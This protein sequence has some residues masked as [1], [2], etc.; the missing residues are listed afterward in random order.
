M[1]LKDDVRRL[2]PHP[3]VRPSELDEYYHPWNLTTDG[4]LGP[5]D[6][7]RYTQDFRPETPW[8]GFHLFTYEF[9]PLL[10]KSA[11]EFFNWSDVNVEDMSGGTWNITLITALLQRR[12]EAERQLL[13]TL[14]KFNGSEGKDLLESYGPSLPFYDELQLEDCIAWTRWDHGRDAI[15]YTLRYIGELDAIRHWLG[16]VLRQS[17]LRDQPARSSLTD[18]KYAGVWVGGVRSD[19][20][21]RFLFDSP[22][23]LYGLFPID[24]RHHLHRTA[25]KGCFDNDEYYR[26]DG[27]LHALRNI[28]PPIPSPADP[29]YD[30]GYNPRPISGAPSCGE[31]CSIQPPH[32]LKLRPPEARCL[33]SGK[34][35]FDPR[36]PYSSYLFME[37]R[38]PRVP[39]AWSRDQTDLRK[40]LYKYSVATAKPFRL[41]LAYPNLADR[42]MPYHPAIYVIP[43]RPR[44][45]GGKQRIF[46]EWNEG[47]YWWLEE[48]SKS[49]RKKYRR[50][51]IHRYEHPL[52]N[53]DIIWSDF[54]W[55]LVKEVHEGHFNEDP[56][57]YDDYEDDRYPRLVPADGRRIYIT[58]QQSEHIDS[59]PQRRLIALPTPSVRRDMENRHSAS[60][61]PFTSTLPPP[62]PPSRSNPCEWD[63]DYDEDFDPIITNDHE[64]EDLPESV[65]P[66]PYSVSTAGRC[67]RPGRSPRP[68]AYSLSSSMGSRR[69][70]S[71]L[72]RPQGCMREETRPRT[73]RSRSPRR[74]DASAEPMVPSSTS[75]S[76]PDYHA[77]YVD[78][79]GSRDV[80]MVDT[81]SQQAATTS[82]SSNNEMAESASIP[83]AE[84]DVVLPPSLSPLVTSSLPVIS[85][86][87]PEPLPVHDVISIPPVVSI[88]PCSAPPSP[89]SLG[90]S[91]STTEG[92]AAGTTSDLW[93]D[94]LRT[95]RRQAQAYI[96]Y[97]LNRSVSP[98]S[99]TEP[100]EL[101]Y[102]KLTS[103]SG[104][105]CYPVR[106]SNV[107][108]RD[109]GPLQ[110]VR[111]VLAAA[112]REGW[113]EIIAISVHMEVDDT[114][115]VEIGFRFPED[116]MA[117]WVRHGRLHFGRTWHISP[118]SSVTGHCF[119]PRAFDTNRKSAS[120]RLH[121]LR[122]C[123]AIEIR[124]ESGQ[125]I[126]PQ[127]AQLQRLLTYLHHPVSPMVSLSILAN[128]CGLLFL[129]GHDL[130]E[131]P[132]D[133]TSIKLDTEWNRVYTVATD[134]T[135][136][137]IPGAL[138]GG[139]FF[140]QNIAY[141]PAP[142]A[143]PS[144]TARKHQRQRN[145][146]NAQR[147]AHSTST[148]I[149][150]TPQGPVL[151]IERSEA[152]RSTWHHAR[153][154]FEAWNSTDL[155]LP[156]FPSKNTKCDFLSSLLI[157]WNWY[158]DCLGVV[159]TTF[160]KHGY[161]S[162]KPSFN[163]NPAGYERMESLCAA[164]RSFQ[165][166]E[167]L[168]KLPGGF[169]DSF[170]AKTE[171]NAQPPTGT[172]SWWSLY[173][174]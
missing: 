58:Y 113:G 117:M 172:F 1:A 116:A 82:S 6:P 164:E 12:Q 166:S 106:I 133:T 28:A 9:D 162:S 137:S 5:Y 57:S 71:S 109:F 70:M 174:C 26:L 129:T 35:D 149:T 55:P 154:K 48:V 45:L 14:G 13:V 89:I 108:F 85:A 50:Q 4:T 77:D 78:P 59:L 90:P 75:I 54:P 81:P 168:R 21:W 72:G 123:E 102:A 36:V 122:I 17:R 136:T 31:R 120:E 69:P 25:V 44:S 95:Q 134:W 169:V 18:R 98:P 16:E 141:T 49:E 84:P 43:K 39:P 97:R 139:L 47:G 119:I 163:D 148:N 29:M 124:L 150:W 10:F 128:E 34:P 74:R 27:F 142:P 131:Q 126:G 94:L 32:E 15:G 151:A 40:R 79:A 51:E 125:L 7:L 86:P 158:E 88:N 80:E 146:A 138:P 38:Y 121:Q 30:A 161:G 33:P 73:D 143:P 153:L 104:L 56:P 99:F 171:V 23:S 20:D 22:L 61:A 165:R 112:K 19:D 68:G 42:K 53:N 114:V 115:S 8:T 91:I 105:G 87:S 41:N 147:Q 103:G 66:P 145:N 60:T 83:Q 52:G 159:R 11:V 93:I 156:P 110:I 157:I 67:E 63:S 140:H 101:K 132:L 62:P 46:R 155:P 173:Q 111:T 100:P 65:P 76:S 37:A 107:E 170:F 135:A 160:D 92:P 64:D 3:G 96:D 127:L 167:R 2:P 118:T 144:K 24:N 152:K 130:A